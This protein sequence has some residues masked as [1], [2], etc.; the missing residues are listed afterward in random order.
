MVR[1]SVTAPE[2]VKT[3]LQQM[4]DEAGRSLAVEA[5]RLLETALRERGLLPQAGAAE[6]KPP[7]G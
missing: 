5:G 2:V 1:F 3:T 4:A 6:A 7:S